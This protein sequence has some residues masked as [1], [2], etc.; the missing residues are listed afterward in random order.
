MELRNTTIDFREMD[1]RIY[2]PVETTTASDIALK[3]SV[4]NHGIHKF[5]APK[6][7]QKLPVLETFLTGRVAANNMP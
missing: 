3:L 7:D 6:H 1:L 2:R 5:V 4:A